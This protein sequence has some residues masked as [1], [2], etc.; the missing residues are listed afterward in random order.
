MVTYPTIKTKHQEKLD[1][2]EI[3][4]KDLKRV[5]RALNRLEAQEYMT[6]AEEDKHMLLSSEARAI[7]LVLESRV[8]SMQY[9]Y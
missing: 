2:I 6:E 5:V 4:L 1:A 7:L 3:Q 9:L 8:Q